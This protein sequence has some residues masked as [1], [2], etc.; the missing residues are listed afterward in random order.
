[1]RN[2]LLAGAKKRLGDDRAIEEE[3]RM[4]AEHARILAAREAEEKW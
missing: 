2:S 4:K 3:R 1:M